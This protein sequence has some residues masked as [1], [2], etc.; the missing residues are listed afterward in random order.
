MPRIR[1][2][3]WAT[4][5]LPPQP[6]SRALAELERAIAQVEGERD[7]HQQIV[8]RGSGV[9]RRRAEVYLKLTENRL[10]QLYRSREVLHHREEPKK[11]EA[12]A[13]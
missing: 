7:R 10:A 4:A 5:S 12:Q 11:E 9:N 13:K 6:R 3:Q 1:R 2:T 8:E